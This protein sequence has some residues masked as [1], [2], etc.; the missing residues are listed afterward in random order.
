M[1]A[2]GLLVLACWAVFLGFWWLSA[3]RV[4]R[5][6]GAGYPQSRMFVRFF[7]LAWVLI[8]LGP[9]RF[10]AAGPL[11]AI[12]VSPS[13]LEGTAGVV[14][15][16]LGM[17]FAC[18]ARVHLGS[19]WGMPMTL[20]EQPEL[21]TSGPYAFVRHPIYTGILVAMLGSALVVDPW[22]AFGV[23]PFAGYFIY[24]AKTEEKA[25]L[26]QF[27]DRYGAYMQRT[28]LLIPFLW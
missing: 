19:N 5:N 22:Y 16:V 21:V 1:G 28:K 14:V 18:W 6:V 11:G 17:A 2:F 24:C 20:K 4:K 26:Q 10:T 13:P 27:P 23:L 12:P 3:F 8:F 15:C 9:R 7:A 25:M